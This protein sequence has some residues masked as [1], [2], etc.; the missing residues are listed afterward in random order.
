MILS[1]KAAIEILDKIDKIDES[2]N[3][4]F[5]L[6]GLTQLIA[7]GKFSDQLSLADEETCSTVFVEDE[8]YNKF[9]EKILNWSK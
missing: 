5:F 9:A 1:K 3:I 2:T 6:G 7:I 8:L 4:I